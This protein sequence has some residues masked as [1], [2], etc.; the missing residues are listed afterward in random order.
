MEN[1]T[2]LNQL[3]DKYLSG[4]ASPEE[5]DLLERS[6]TIASMKR[7]LPERDDLDADHLDQVAKDSWFALMTKINH[8]ELRPVRLWPRIAIA[9]AAIAAITLGLWLYNSADFMH[10][11]KGKAAY[12]YAN[13][14]APGKAGATLTLSN[15]KKIS[16]ST[17]PSGELKSADGQLIYQANR[18]GKPR[19]MKNTLSTANAETYQLHLPDG[20][21]VWLNAGSEITYATDLGRGKERRVSFKGEAYFKIAKD[22]SHPFI[23]ETAEQQL[24][25][26]GTE[27]NVNSYPEEPFVR[28]TLVEGSVRI[29]DLVVLKPSQQARHSLNQIEVAIVKTENFT[30]WKDGILNFEN[31]RL[32][33]VMRKIARWYDVDVQY[34]GVEKTPKTYSG[35][36]SKYGKIS[37]VLR[38][39]EESEA[40]RFKVAGRKV[41]VIY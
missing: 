25:V 23:V 26:L 5:I 13:D 6:Y 15:G 18:S 37:T 28:T 24:K 12:Q 2:H 31:E 40:I 1:T 21:L 36:I 4:Q 41:T 34:E 16:L 38:L 39:L 30:D 3:I 29:N 33:S 19:D 7:R 11:S 20:S 9:A 8:T 32:Q 10:F 27:F 22:K 35:T 17:A 14:I